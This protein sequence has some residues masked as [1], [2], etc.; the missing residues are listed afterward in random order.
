LGYDYIRGYAE[1]I[2]K[3]RNYQKIVIEFSE[4]LRDHAILIY[5]KLKQLLRE[6]S[7]ITINGDSRFGS[8]DIDF[9]LYR[10]VNPDLVIHIGHTPFPNIQQIYKS[11]WPIDIH[12]IPVYEDYDNIRWI[13]DEL[14]NIKYRKVIL[15]SSI[16]FLPLLRRLYYILVKEK[17]EENKF[18]VP[19]N[20]GLARGQVIGCFSSYLKRYR[21]RFDAIYVI[22]S[23][24]FHALGVALYSGLDTYLIDIRKREIVSMK[25]EVRRVK[26]LIAWN[27]Y[28]AK[29]AKFFGVLVAKNPIQRWISHYNTILRIL[30]RHRKEYLEILLNRVNEEV[31][32]IFDD[33]DAFVTAS[34]P[35]ISIDDISRFK[36]PI[37]NLEQLLIL[38]GYKEFG[39]VYP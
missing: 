19:K 33:V 27:I 17:T 2:A 6:G 20:M 11:K 38:F 25:N 14:L 34:C 7:N 28:R 39:D 15:V 8:C 22:G 21:N 13:L 30:K 9:S 10:E 18:Y 31:L 16:Q 32:R 35:R 36:K 4:G 1:I 26:S 12:Y 5:K 3:N 29:E 24:K 23:G 37:L